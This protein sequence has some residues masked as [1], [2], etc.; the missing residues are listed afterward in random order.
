MKYLHI[1][2][3]ISIIILIF[4]EIFSQEMETLDL[5]AE[6]KTLPKIEGPVSIALAEGNYTVGF[7][8]DF[9]TIDSVFN[10]LSIDGISG[11]VT[12]ELIDDLYS[13]PENS[14]G[15]LLNGPVPGAGPDSRIKIKPAQNKNVTIEGDGE[16]V[17]YFLNTSYV[18]IDGV[19]L[20][21][22]TT[23]K[24]NSYQNSIYQWNDG[25]T[26][27]NNSK[28]NVIQNIVFDCEDYTRKGSAILFLHQYGNFTP[29]SNL[30]QNNF[31]Q[32]AA[33]GISI[34]SLYYRATG[35]VIRGNIIGSEKDS[36]ISMGINVTFG[37]YTII[38]NNVIQNLRNKGQI[39]Y[40]PGIVSVA[41]TGD[42]IRNNVVYNVSVNCG[43]YGGIGI[44]LTGTSTFKGCINTVYN[45]M[46][47]NIQSLS[48]EESSVACGIE[49]RNQEYAKIYYNSIYL[50]GAGNNK[51]GSAAL[52]ITTN[53]LN[54]F[55]KNNILL[56][57]RNESPNS[58]FALNDCSSG[59]LISDYNNV[60]IAEN[61]NNFLIRK[62]G[63]DY[64]NL[65]DWQLTGMDIHSFNE[66]PRFENPG[67]HIDRRPEVCVAMAGTPIYGILTDI[68]GEQRSLQMPDIGADEFDCL[69]SEV[70][71][72]NLPRSFELGQN[73]PNPFNPGTTISWNLAEESIV[74]LKVFNALGEEVMTVISNEHQNAGEH[75][76]SFICNSLL[77]SGVYFYRLEAG[78][79]ST[80]SVLNYVET[81]KMM[82]LK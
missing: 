67:L 11:D 30:I 63:V 31:V 24:I 79:L 53:C 3:T 19:N 29:D 18:T 43:Y 74:T 36:L 6:I 71:E 52:Y 5:R 32:K 12:I 37:Q 70:Q 22:S 80:S 56:N 77:T 48:P 42:V 60:Y 82:L 59:S 1:F 47:Y 27:L 15:F 68:D 66:M 13:L 72:E 55:V 21:G 40:S 44:L 75:S 8:G 78:S 45:N 4:P 81:K 16:A 41:G 46:I 14:S 38:E 20:T 28:H 50:S 51:S 17:L 58:A 33:A 73:F 10:K 49:L 26:F 57:T 76:T 39:V 9:P 7:G 25:I 61:Q 35:N 2:I 64:K 65:Y 34:A 54:S 23:L 69:V 62:N